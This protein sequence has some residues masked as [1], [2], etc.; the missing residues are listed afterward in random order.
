M[1]TSLGPL[2]HWSPRSRLSGIK[3][4]GL[5]PGLRNIN[6]PTYHDGT[7]ESGEFRQE[8]VCASPDPATAWSHSHG[9]WKSGGTF[10]LWQFW[11]EPTDHVEILPMWGGRVVEVRIF[12]RIRKAR[13]RWIGERTVEV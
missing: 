2:Y 11:L 1:S 3:R 8:A 13:L 4:R 6:G 7:P 12:G 9:A 10:D 5:V